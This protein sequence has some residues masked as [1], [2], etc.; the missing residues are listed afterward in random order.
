MSR[1][2]AQ[3]VA[4]LLWEQ[5]AAGSN[6]ASPTP[7]PVGDGLRAD[8]IQV[9]VEA[10]A[11]PANMPMRPAATTIVPGVS[12]CVQTHSPGADAASIPPSVCPKMARIDATDA[13]PPSASERVGVTAE[14]RPWEQPP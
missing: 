1:G 13:R 7:R 11:W 5:G 10:D 2:I 9:R 3:L 6:P 12:S 14:L 8:R 4:H